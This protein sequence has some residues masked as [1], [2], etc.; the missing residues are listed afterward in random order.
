MPILSA[1]GGGSHGPKHL[2]PY[3]R[4]GCTFNSCRP[5]S[6]TRSRQLFANERHLHGLARWD[7]W[8]EIVLIPNTRAETR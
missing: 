3:E 2:L 7:W 8:L 1:I 4:V 5:R 6:P